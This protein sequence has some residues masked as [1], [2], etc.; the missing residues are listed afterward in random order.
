MPEPPDA[1]E[2]PPVVAD[3]VRITVVVPV[4]VVVGVDVVET[5]CP[6]VSEPLPVRVPNAVSVRVIVPESD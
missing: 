6:V 1:L 5:L 2:V 4:P 3:T